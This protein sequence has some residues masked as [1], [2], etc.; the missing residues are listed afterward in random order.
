LVFLDPTPDWDELLD[1]ATEHAPRRAPMYQRIRDE[2]EGA[3][4]AIMAQ[5]E[6]GRQAEW[7]ALPTTR[8]QA[9]AAL[10]PKEV[11]VVQISGS[12]GEQISGIMHDKIQF[13]DAWLARHIPHARH[14]HAIHSGHAVP[15]TDSKLVVNEVER[16]LRLVQPVAK[17]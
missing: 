15:A 5:Q 12:A 10:P 13:F 2:S 16:L 1:W 3:M 4:Q 7:E 6:S 14:V 11:A 8:R 17:R 9:R